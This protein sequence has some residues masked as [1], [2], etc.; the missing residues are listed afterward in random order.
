MIPHRPSVNALLS[1]I[2][3]V[4]HIQ[5]RSLVSVSRKA[6]P[7]AQRPAAW[8][9][10][11]RS[12]HAS[13]AQLMK[14]PY[15]VIGVDKNASASEI[16]KAYYQLA[17]KYHPDI[18]KEKDADKRFQDI[19]SAYEILSDENKKKE[20]DQFGA[21][22]FQQGGGPGGFRGGSDADFNPFSNF[23]GFGGFGGGAAGQRGF[24][25]EDIFSAFGGGGDGA[26]GGRSG[27]IPIYQGQDVEISTTITLEDVAL[28]VAK[29]V[30]Y[31]T[32]DDCGTCNGTGLKKGKSKTVCRT[33]NGAGTTVHVIQGGFQMASTC[34]TCG[35]SGVVIPKAS[36]CGT[37][38][39]RGVVNNTKTTTI[40]IPPGVSDGTRLR[41]S[42]EGDSPD[43]ASDAGVQKVK[44]DL[45]I[46]VKVKPHPTF[47]RDRSD[48]LY[49]MD[50]PM[51]TAALGGKVEVPTLLRGNIRLNV[52]QATQNGMVITIPEEG[53]PQAGRRGQ[54]GDYKV[55]LRVKTLKPTT[56][57]QTALLEALADAFH[58]ETARRI[59]PSW[60]PE[61]TDFDAETNNAAGASKDDSEKGK[62]V[63]QFLKN[64]INR[65]THA[66][67]E[68]QK[69]D[70]K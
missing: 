23:G 46:R 66:H 20:Y 35:G 36:E 42:H 64:L 65:I 44:G 60:K 16:K 41:M 24:N 55:T 57:T 21:A 62:S 17:K 3:C 9:V 7:T 39:S 49:N 53:L 30:K 37:C 50:I 1:S 22:A 6:A 19:Q 29:E 34:H 27:G 45:L 70:K 33:C 18:N 4:K 8:R 15:K 56:A 51:T 14:D 13:A 63:G 32:L 59:N 68:D 67:E 12:F 38:H 47:L 43:V 5:S 2:K 54:K 10:A 58:D 48:L 52:P 61:A 69:S 28:G 31:S 25:F 26:R 40:D 11:A